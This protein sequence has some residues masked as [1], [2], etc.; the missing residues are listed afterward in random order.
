MS[1]C[2]SCE[3]DFLFVK[4]KDVSHKGNAGYIRMYIKSNW[5]TV[6]LQHAYP[7]PYVFNVPFMLKSIL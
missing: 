3:L 1:K 5:H 6:G 7:S 4:C 2:T